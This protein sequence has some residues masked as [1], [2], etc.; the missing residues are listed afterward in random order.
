MFGVMYMDKKLNRLATF[1]DHLGDKKKKSY[2]SPAGFYLDHRKRSCLVK[3]L[4]L[5]HCLLSLGMVLWSLQEIWKCSMAWNDKAF[6][7]SHV[8]QFHQWM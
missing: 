5:R 4:Y 8:K 7:V 3:D 1:V 2:L 6:F